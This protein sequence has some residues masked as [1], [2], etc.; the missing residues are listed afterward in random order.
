MTDPIRTDAPL[1]DSRSERL[2]RWVMRLIEQVGPYWTSFIITTP[3]WLVTNVAVDVGYFADGITFADRPVSGLMPWTM[4][5]LVGYPVIL[6]LVRI[7]ERLGKV[8]GDLRGSETKYRNL[9]E[10]SLQGVCVHR[11]L[12][13]VFVSQT[14]AE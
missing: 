11:E 10:G 4:P 3:V 9:L 14:F 7:I 2:L 5:F 12:V 8:E 13:P 6:I 1:L